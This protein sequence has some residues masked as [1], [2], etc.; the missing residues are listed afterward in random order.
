V[1]GWLVLFVSAVVEALLLGLELL[2]V[3]DGEVLPGVLGVERVGVVDGILVLD[4]LEL[5]ERFMAEPV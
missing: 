2:G 4:M 5:R 3:A 1:L